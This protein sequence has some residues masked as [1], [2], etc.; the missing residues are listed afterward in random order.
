MK[1]GAPSRGPYVRVGVSQRRIV[2]AKQILYGIRIDLHDQPLGTPPPHA[3][4]ED[5]CNP[6]NEP[7]LIEL[8]VLRGPA[9]TRNVWVC[10]K[11][12][13]HVCTR[14]TCRLGRLANR[15]EIVCPL[16]SIV[17]A[18]ETRP[19]Q[20]SAPEWTPHWK[21][22]SVAD[23]KRARYKP[24]APAKRISSNAQERAANVKKNLPKKAAVLQ[25]A[26]STISLLLYSSVRKTINNEYVKQC[27]ARCAR[28]IIQYR[29]TCDAHNQLP[30]LTRIIE[31]TNNAWVEGMPFVI[32]NR[33]PSV[34][35]LYGNI[36]CQIWD[37][38]LR[39]MLTPVMIK[40]KYSMLF[41][42]GKRP[43]LDQVILG[44][45][46]LMRNGYA[47]KGSVMLPRDPFLE[48]HLPMQK[49]LHRF[50]IAK[51]SVAPGMGLL[52]DMY[53]AALAARIPEQKLRLDYAALEQ[54]GYAVIHSSTNDDALPSDE[55]P[56][57]EQSRVI[58][59]ES[60][61]HWCKE[62]RQRFTSADDLDGHYCW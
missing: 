31:L 33:D 27:R 22:V 18:T 30:R 12:V 4:H 3:C 28:D 37:R 10:N 58:E 9:M 20:R 24:P 16:S 46:Y 48:T 35:G 62:C 61:Y 25:R 53:N 6:Q 2:A 36:I 32:L 38:L 39:F 57:T 59:S 43:N 41:A 54:Y 60:R 51:K 17:Y 52:R 47:P 19:E 56:R 29:A 7:D 15:G 55:T 21:P 26:H 34:I 11:G 8:G 40:G 44:A 5:F 14:D 13:T 45:L 49:D 23:E 42:Q 50:E 1:R